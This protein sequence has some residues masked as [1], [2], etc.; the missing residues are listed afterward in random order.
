MSAVRNPKCFTKPRPP[1]ETI[2]SEMRL[3][4]NPKTAPKNGVLKDLLLEQLINS[5]ETA[6]DQKTV[7]PKASFC[8]LIDLI[9]QLIDL[10]KATASPSSL[11]W[12]LRS[13]WLGHFKF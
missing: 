8:F 3:E 1:A 4:R 6:S 2:S 5:E 10:I 9:D 11:A 13:S 12:I 7:C